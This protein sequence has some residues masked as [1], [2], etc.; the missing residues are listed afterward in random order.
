[1]KRFV[2][3]SC[4]ILIVASLALSGGQKEAGKEVAKKATIEF[5]S[6]L[7]EYEARYQ[8]VWEVFMKENPEIDIEMVMLNDQDFR[9]QI[10]SRMAA[11][12]APELFGGSGSQQVGPTKNNYKNFL[13]IK[14]I[15]RYWDRLPGGKDTW[16]KNSRLELGRE[17]NGIY[18]LTFEM[19][20]WWSFLYHRDM[21]K[22]AGLG[23]K[24]SVKTVDDLRQ[25]LA[26]WKGYLD[27]QGLLTPLD[28][29]AGSCGS[30]CSGQEFFQVYAA[31]EVES[32]DRLDDVY[33]GKASFTDPQ[34]GW[35]FEWMK[36]MV[37]KK[38]LPNEWW[39]RDWEQDME[40]NNIA[41]KVPALLHG[42][43]M[44][45]KLEQANPDV[46]L[47]GFPVPTKSGKNRKIKVSPLV[48]SKY[49]WASP[50]NVVDRESF[51]TGAFQKALNF[52]AGPESVKMQVEDWGELTVM[53]FESPL[54]V[55]STQW[56]EVGAEV[57]KGSWADVSFDFNPWGVSQ[58]PHLIPGEAD[59]IL[60]GQFIFDQVIFV[61]QGKKSVKE[62]QQAIQ[63]QLERAYDNR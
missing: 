49:S 54:E 33:T 51:K 43:W 36:E 6:Q 61:I 12:T 37:D 17:A 57:G 14:E 45:Q 60:G 13:D 28:L 4:F 62:A 31:M 63:D 19:T 38:W 39:T 21:A 5:V 34:W 27:S 46:D 29:G 30:W 25:W 35:F 22:E 40:S 9:V 42:P 18:G 59:P 41:K 15:Y 7:P 48:P 20:Y 55:T 16:L 52:W 2:F 53:E 32:L 11:G 3:V 47:T 1:M 10:D 26:K 50:A 8:A 56:Q 23:D 24:Y 58:A 44:W